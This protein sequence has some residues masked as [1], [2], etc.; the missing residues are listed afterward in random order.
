L[1]AVTPKSPEGDF[2]RSYQTPPLGGW[3]VE[4]NCILSEFAYKLMEFDCKL[5]VFAY[6]LMEF[7]CILMEFA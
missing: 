6:K 2:G 7:N 3:G 5:S 1:V 4:F